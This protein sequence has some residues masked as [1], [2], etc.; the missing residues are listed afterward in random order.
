MEYIL[1]VFAMLLAIV[2]LVGAIVPGIPGPPLSFV[3]L[4]LLS[5]C[6]NLEIGWTVLLVTAILAVAVTIL[7]YVAPVW[8]TNKK[9]GSKYAMWGAVIGM[10]LGMPFGFLGVVLGPFICALLGEMIYGTPFEKA[11]NVA[12]VSFVA[13]MLTT[14]VKFIYSFVL[15][16]MIAIKGWSVIFA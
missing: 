2:G 9:G 8:L 7:D 16:I 4:L 12:F 3:G 5:F 15:F 11:L 13:F 1:L 6:S 14:G 10:F